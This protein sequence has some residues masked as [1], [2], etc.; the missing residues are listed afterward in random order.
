V[1]DHREPLRPSAPAIVA[2]LVEPDIV[3][4]LRAAGGSIESLRRLA[5]QIG[6][7]RSAITAEVHKLVAAG[8]VTLAR[9]RH[10]T[11]VSLAAVARPN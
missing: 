1:V 4:C 2:Q 7:S 5:D 11:V 6:R 9:G 3:R 8:L 10:G